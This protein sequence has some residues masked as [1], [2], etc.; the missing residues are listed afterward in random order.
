MVKAYLSHRRENDGM[1]HFS[2]SL[3]DW[4][5]GNGIEL[6]VDCKDAELSRPIDEFVSKLETS[7]SVVFLLNRRFFLSPWCMGELYEFLARRNANYHGFFIACDNF[8]NHKELQQ[9]FDDFE[10]SLINHWR[11]VAHHKN[12]EDAKE[13]ALTFVDHIPEMIGIIRRLNF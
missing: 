13:E 5:H 9:F 1:S 6:Q 2:R 7:S 4:A 10:K 12:S 8:L 3:I 11:E